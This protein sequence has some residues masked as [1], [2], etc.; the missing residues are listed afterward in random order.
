M[1]KAV[2]VLVFWSLVMSE[3]AG[4]EDWLDP[5]DMLNFDPATKTMRNK[6]MPREAT[7]GQEDTSESASSSSP[8]DHSSQTSTGNEKPT[9]TARCPVQKECKCNQAGLPLTRQYVKSLIEH[10]H[11]QMPHGQSEDYNMYITLSPD[12]VQILKN[13][14]RVGDQRHIH[15]V[16]EILVGMVNRVISSRQGRIE[17]AIEWLENKIGV[18]LHRVLQVLSI[19]GLASLI[20]VIEVKLQIPWR[21]RLWQL[22]ILM[23]VISVPWTWYEL[24]KQAEIKQ[25]SYAM[26]DF[27]AECRNGSV[28]YWST[29]KSYFLLQDDKCHAYYEHLMID[30]VIKVPPTKAIAVTFVRFFLAP[31]KD[32]GTAVSEFIRALL[33]DLPLTLYP[34]AIAIV[35]MFSFMFLFMWFGYSIRLPFFL[36]IERPPQVSIADSRLNEALTESSEKI[37]KQLEELQH[38]IEDS[39]T[40]TADKLRHLEQVQQLAI[41]YSMSSTPDSPAQSPTVTVTRSNPSQPPITLAAINSS[42]VPP[43]LVLGA[44]AETDQV[45]SGTS[46]IEINGISTEE[47]EV[48][49]LLK[50]DRNG[51]DSVTVTSEKDEGETLTGTQ[52]SDTQNQKANIDTLMPSGVVNNSNG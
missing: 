24:L 52:N 21:R 11:G 48:E 7:P 20:L 3:K 47:P 46:S 40:N 18:S 30:P 1:L 4:R 36:T 51:L 44:N 2:L 27:P 39:E 12:H 41:E 28:D 22:I 9:G 5:N 16:N 42:Y 32:V 17:K 43:T 8:T 25:Q 34:V 15:D 14:V 38:R 45:D 29:I 33:I 50:S 35:A 13:F 26:K 10:L 6:P 19:G 49:S 31:L 37:M 23:F